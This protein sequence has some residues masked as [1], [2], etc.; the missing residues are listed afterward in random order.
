MLGMW[1]RVASKDDAYLQDEFEHASVRA[2]RAPNTILQPPLLNSTPLNGVLL[3]G[4][5]LLILVALTE[6]VL[7]VSKLFP[8][9]VIGAYVA[10][11]A[12]LLA[13]AAKFL[14]SE[15]FGLANF[16]TLARWALAALLIGA[17]AGDGSARLMWFCVVVAT[18]ALTLDG[19]DGY[20]ARR[21]GE[22]SVFGA[23]FDMETDAA[24][25]LVLCMLVWYF[26][27]AG[28]WI[29]LAGFMRYAFVAAS[30][31]LPR[32]RRPLPASMRRKTA[33]V[34][35][36]VALVAALAPIFSPDGASFLAGTGLLFLTMSFMTDVTWLARYN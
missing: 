33:C 35:Q 9:I 10:G 12:C 14:H 13:C 19:F 20:I 16:V 34:V 2:M 22:S 8:V 36:L 27:R 11:A 6:T 30:W 15:R 28:A 17:F 1:R 21:S 31:V 29:L 5:A 4:L 18:I 25:M 24:I 3:C 23:R 26:D 7:A 32:L